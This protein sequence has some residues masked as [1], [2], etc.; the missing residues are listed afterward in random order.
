MT[1]AY[2][3]SVYQFWDLFPTTAQ[4]FYLGESMVNSGLTGRGEIL[5]ART[6]ARYWQGSVTVMS[7]HRLDI[8]GIRALLHALQEPGASFMAYDPRNLTGGAYLG[9]Q[10]PSLGSP[11]LDGVNADGSVRIREL[12]EYYII[13]RGDYMAFQYGSNPTRFAL[14][15]FAEDGTAT[16]EGLSPYL[17]VVPLV[18]PGYALGTHVTMRRGGC[19]AVI[20]PDSVQDAT[21]RGDISE[22]LSFRWQQTL[23]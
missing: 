12:P 19:K 23:R 11:K 3:L 2:P 15:Q 14:H 16:Q 7:E 13:K 17:S 10:L 4:T 18:R 20:V 8:S 21:T 9:Q 6:G 5:R 22:G 1:L